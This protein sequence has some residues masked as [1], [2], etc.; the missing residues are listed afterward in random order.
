MIYKCLINMNLLIHFLNKNFMNKIIETIKMLN[1]MHLLFIGIL[2]ELIG[3][4]L[5][6]FNATL[7]MTFQLLAFLVFIFALIKFFN[8]KVK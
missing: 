1:P 8:K 6:R 3:L 5:E 7:A 4:L 2:T